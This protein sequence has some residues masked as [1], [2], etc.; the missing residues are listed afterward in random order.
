MY[1]LRS[2]FSPS[3]QPHELILVSQ[4]LQSYTKLPSVSARL[5]IFTTDYT[6]LIPCIA[7]FT[8][9]IERGI[10]QVHSLLPPELAGWDGSITRCWLIYWSAQTPSDV[11]T[12]NYLLLITCC[13]CIFYSWMPFFMQFY[14][15]YVKSLFNGKVYFTVKEGLVRSSVQ[16]VQHKEGY[17]QGRILGFR[18]E[19]NRYCCHS[20][21]YLNTQPTRGRLC[22][23]FWNISWKW[24]L[25]KV[26]H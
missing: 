1:D 4:S 19:E 25:P 20:V 17:C 7:M 10:C 3:G 22:L 12:V 13:F 23:L 21:Q 11:S 18:E 26:W 15:Y 14:D 8:P 16:L 9:Q 6:S 2:Q 5:H 24:S